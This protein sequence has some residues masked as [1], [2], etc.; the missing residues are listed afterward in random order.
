MGLR[1]LLSLVVPV[2]GVSSGGRIKSIKCSEGLKGSGTWGEGNSTSFDK[3][4]GR[5]A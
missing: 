5:F 3:V 1:S 4:K 2:P